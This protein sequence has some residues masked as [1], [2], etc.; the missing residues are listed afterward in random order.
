VCHDES[1]DQTGRNAPASSPY[2]L[3]LGVF[4]LEFHVERFGKILAQEVGCAGLEGFPVLHE[5]FDAVGVLGAREA[6]AGRF[7][8]GYDRHRHEIFGERAVDLEHANGLFDG[9]LFSC[10]SGVAFLPQEF[11]GAQEQARAHFPADHVRPLVDEDR[12][13]AVALDPIAVGIPD[14]RFGS[15]AHDQFFLEFGRRIDHNAIRAIHQAAVCDDGA[16][17]GEAFD[18]LGFFR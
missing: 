15:R 7:D 11:H 8:T 4:V 2:V 18:M 9:F 16:F 14:D 17:F 10:V 5:G 1:A 12:E 3:E 6:L 13:V